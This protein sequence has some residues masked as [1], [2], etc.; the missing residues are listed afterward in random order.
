MNI[1]LKTTLNLFVPIALLSSCK[2]NEHGCIDST[3]TNY[4]SDAVINNNSCC[5]ECYAYFD[6]LVIMDTLD[7]EYC[8]AERDSIENNSY[9]IYQQRHVSGAGETIYP[10]TPG[11][12]PVYNPE[13]GTPEMMYYEY[14][15]ICGI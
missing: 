8:N 6:Y 15:I 5:Y 10:D 2:N 11:A 3:A 14:S 13:D 1:L 9:S 12:I 7:G 4:N